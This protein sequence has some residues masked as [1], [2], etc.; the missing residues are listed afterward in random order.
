MMGKLRFGICVVLA[1]LATACAHPSRFRPARNLEAKES[2][3]TI[4]LQATTPVGFFANYDEG[5]WVPLTPTFALRYG[6]TDWLEIGGQLGVMHEHLDLKL[7]LLRS[8]HLDLS[9]GL[10]LGFTLGSTVLHPEPH[11]MESQEFGVGPQPMPLD[12]LELFKN[13]KKENAPFF[14]PS[15]SLPIFL[16]IN[17][18]PWLSF[19]AFGAGGNVAGAWVLQAGGGIEFSSIPGISLRPHVSFLFPQE[20]VVQ[21]GG[22][23]RPHFLFGLDLAFGRRGERE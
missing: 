23:G 9:V 17:P 10:D 16:G 20:E 6:L 15:A 21:A 14:A 7:Q 5:N 11:G 22:E 4:G 8:R 13:E 19:I 18:T 3:V 12:S 1:L 2:E